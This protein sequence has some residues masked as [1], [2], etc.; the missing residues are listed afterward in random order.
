VID[1]GR[2]AGT[3]ERRTPSGVPVRLEETGWRLAVGGPRWGF[4]IAHRAPRAVVVGGERVRIHDH[5]GAAL[6]AALVIDLIAV[7]ARSRAARSR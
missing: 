1:V 6:M 2:M 5:V 4:A 3:V 7:I